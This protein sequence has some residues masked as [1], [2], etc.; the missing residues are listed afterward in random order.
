MTH[1]TH[2]SIAHL[3]TVQAYAMRR[4]IKSW[5]K[6]NIIMAT[7]W[8][9]AAEQAA[10]RAKRVRAYDRTSQI[11]QFQGAVATAHYQINGARNT[12]RGSY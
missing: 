8:F 3:A 12:H 6:H 11:Q 1:N 5:S 4:Y 7:H 9:T 2:N 10:Q